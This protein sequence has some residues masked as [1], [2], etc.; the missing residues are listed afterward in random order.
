MSGIFSG[1]DELGSTVD[2]VSII[3]FD[4]MA[5][6][7]TASLALTLGPAVFSANVRRSKAWYSMI[8]TM[9]IFPLL[10]LLNVG[11]QFDN[12][13]APPIGLCILQAGFI[14]AG[15]PA[16]CTASVLCFLTDMTL[17]LRSVI[18][19]EKRNKTLMSA[20]IVMPSIIFA[21]VFFEAIALVNSNRGVHFD[22]THMFC[23]SDNKGPQV[24]IS[25]ILT[26]ISLA[27]TLG[28]E[29]WAVSILYRNWSAVRTFRRSQQDL[30]LSVMLRLGVFTLVTGF[31]AVLGAVTLP[32]NLQ[33]GAIWNI[34]LVTVPLLAA[35][36]FGTRRDII[37]SYAFW[38]KGTT[39]GFRGDGVDRSVR[40]KSGEV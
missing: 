26:M 18:F 37:S 12:E 3:A 24:K 28:M 4:T 13:V 9:M 31:A 2:P 20:L 38:K 21:S 10:Y 7:A 14:Y 40:G 39:D 29:V 5:V 11:S 15:P 25:A 32:A 30:Q 6:V 17:G 19:N 23:E 33:G 34:F 16:Y 8:T 1:G 36:S 35:L 27:L 22:S